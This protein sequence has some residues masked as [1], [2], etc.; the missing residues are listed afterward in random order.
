MI[1]MDRNKSGDM[2]ASTSQVKSSTKKGR[3]PSKS[4]QTIT[5]VF[6][7]FD[8][9]DMSIGKWESAYG[10]QIGNCAQRVNI[11]V[12]GYPKYDKVQ[13]QNL[14][15]ESK[16]KFH[17]DD[18]KGSK[19]KKF[20]EAV[21]A[22]FRKHKS[23]L[24]SRFITKRTAPPPDSPSANI[25]PWELYE[26]YIT[27]EQWKEFETYCN[28]DEFK[29]L[30]EKGKENAKNNKHRHHLGSKSYERARVD[31][32]KTNRIPAES[33]TSSTT[34]STTSCVM[35]EKLRN[36]SL[37]WILAR[38]TRNA[39]GSWAID[40]KNTETQQIANA[41]LENLQK[42]DEGNNSSDVIG[43]DAL[44]KA[45]GKRDHCGHVKALGRCG[46]GVS[47]TQVFGK[48]YKKGK[49][50][51]QGGCSLEELESM[52]AT[53]TQEFEAR[54]EE[55]VEEKLQER[56]EERLEQRVAM[57]VKAYLANL[58]PQMTGDVEAF[59]GM[60]VITNMEATQSPRVIEVATKCRLALKDEYNQY[61]VV[62]ADGTVYPVTG[63]VTHNLKM[64]PDHYR[65]SV[66]NLYPDCA[67]LDI[68][69]PSPDGVTKLGKAKSSF[70]LWPIDMVFF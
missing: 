18:P 55:K 57:E 47:H 39:D 30:S 34:E 44:D 23:W 20:H 29:A 52:K 60:Q 46:V 12:K 16:R 25:K 68:P 11:N 40:P 2:D 1:M 19:E 9:F 48:G 38:Q 22:R 69:V 64:L 3:G 31:W 45:L 27:E 8:E 53:L 13:K 62:V 32:S 36:R 33:S 54:L 58:L 17:I 65:V 21:G 15:E 10:K 24:V 50:S 4:V 7:E 26:G 6:L 63:E 43:M 70:V 66:D 37:Y 35:S 67:L 14:W 49:S 51:G 61:L 41:I 42:N 5:P 28:T 59:Q 56:I